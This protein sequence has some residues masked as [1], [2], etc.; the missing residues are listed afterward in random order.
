MSTA[1]RMFQ[2][3]SNVWGTEIE[4]HLRKVAYVPASPLLK[5]AAPRRSMRLCRRTTTSGR[6][7]TTT[8]CT[9]TSSVPLGTA[10]PCGRIQG[11]CNGTLERYD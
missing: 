5:S 7:S 1:F 11:G 8:T 10:G 9:S 2:G 6:S 4:K 3:V